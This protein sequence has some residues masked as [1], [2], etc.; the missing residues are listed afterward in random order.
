MAVTPAGCYLSVK[1]HRHFWVALTGNDNTPSACCGAVSAVG[2]L[3]TSCLL[4]VCDLH[5]PLVTVHLAILALDAGGAADT[6]DVP[7]VLMDEG[8]EALAVM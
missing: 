8:V 2:G 5:Y 3:G 6:T 4:A 1:M 7:D